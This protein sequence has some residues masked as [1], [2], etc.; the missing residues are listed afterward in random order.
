[1]ADYKAAVGTVL[2]DYVPMLELGLVDDVDATIEKM[3]KECYDSGLQNVLDEFD[4][5]YEAWKATR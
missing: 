2:K 1:M 5:Q 3:I 4:A